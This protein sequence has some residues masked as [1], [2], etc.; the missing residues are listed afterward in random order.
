MN[1]SVEGCPAFDVNAQDIAQV[2]MPSKNDLAIELIQDDTRYFFFRHMPQCSRLHY[3][4]GCINTQRWG[5]AF[6]FPH[7]LQ[8]V[9]FINGLVDILDLV[10]ILVG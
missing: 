7:V 10:Y 4:V 1:V 6:P 8:R 9:A 3:W 5:V 2:T